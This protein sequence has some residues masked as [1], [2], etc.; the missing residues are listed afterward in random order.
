[1]AVTSSTPVES[2]RPDTQAARAPQIAR[3]VPRATSDREP[4]SVTAMDPLT[5]QGLAAMEAMALGDAALPD[6][7]ALARAL[8][9]LKSAIG[10]D[11]EA[12]EEISQTAVAVIE[13][14]LA[15]LGQYLRQRV[16]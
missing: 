5:P 9:A 10:Q 15:K 16:K 13:D 1:M 6:A 2:V 14:E 8:E 7:Y 4:P 3:R 12:P 11:T